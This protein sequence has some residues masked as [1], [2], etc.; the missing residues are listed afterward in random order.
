MTPST[1]SSRYLR[2]VAVA[3][4]A[5]FLGLIARFWHPV[6]GFTALLQ[7][8]SAHEAVSIAAFHEYP[9][10]VFRD[11][12]AYDGFQYA[13]IAYH[14][15]LTADELRP[16]VD[17]LAYRARRILLPAL[18]WL[19]AGGQAGLIVHVY[20][21][22]NI[23]CWLILAAL[24]WRVLRVD[25]ARGLIA[26][27]GV[28][29]S[30][31]ALGS[32][33]LALTDLPA[34]TLVAAALWA[35]E[36]GRPRSAVGWLA[37]AALTRET[38]LVAWPGLWDA[39]G[40]SPAILQRNLFRFALAAAPLAVWLLYIHWRVGSPNQGWNNFTWP[41]I[42]L[43]EKWRECLTAVSRLAD[44]QLAWSTVFAT[45]GL[46]FQAAFILAHPR[47][48]DP[49]WRVGAA[50]VLMMLCLG[51]AVWEGFPGAVMR[52]LLPLNLA[53][54]VLARRTR[55]PLAW[56]LACNLTVFSGLLALRDVP[57][58]PY[59]DAILVTR[60]WDAVGVVQLGDGWY[61]R[62]RDAH[63]QWSWAASHGRLV[64]TTWPR[65][66]DV[67][68][69]LTL[70]M[71]SL[72]PRTVRALADGREIWRATIGEQYRTVEL[73]VPAG[74]NGRMELDFVTDTP[75]VAEADRPDARLLGF[76][77]YDPAISVSD[78]ASASR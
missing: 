40:K 65:S 12:G 49:W 42:G 71:R 14:P 29:F 39:P 57:T 31:G 61:D 46:T 45:A 67:R 43:L 41:V 63:H 50:Y 5:L 76:A 6:Y 72:A 19:L 74:K 73:P 7:L 52:V 4:A 15:L 23:A 77:L 64:I 17:N 24:L 2:L 59:S 28:M 9:V 1:R 51:T 60:N 54:N 25:D 58:F 47:T 18:A 10:F 78:S 44:H 13:Q 75:A 36:R 3:A 55:A 32:V 22:L 8:D 26:W 11:T 30:A 33:R 56:L 35:A 66:V 27:A 38:S 48:A 37:A 16:A 34:L 68:A 62:E 69:R 21:V 53:C 70:R 20:T